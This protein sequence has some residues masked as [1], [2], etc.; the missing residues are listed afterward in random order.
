M[1]VPRADLLAAVRGIRGAEQAAD[2]LKFIRYDYRP[3]PSMLSP[4]VTKQLREYS[5]R[6]KVSGYN[7]ETGQAED[8]FF[9]ISTEDLLPRGEIE[10]IALGHSTN[11]DNYAPFEPE[12]AEL[13]TA[14]I[15]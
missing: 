13:E 12:Q 1:G 10:S 8:R 4:A 3:D 9:N 6:V 14:T 2:R 15:R 11:T 7:P 5:F